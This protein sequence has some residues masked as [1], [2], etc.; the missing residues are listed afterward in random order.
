[1]DDRRSLLMSKEMQMKKLPI[2]LVLALVASALW[3]QDYGK[4]G[5]GLSGSFYK[6]TEDNTSGTNEDNDTTFFITGSF[7]A[8]LGDKMELRPSLTYGMVKET[9]DGS[10]TGGWSYFGVEFGLYWHILNTNFFRMGPGVAAGGFLGI[11]TYPSSDEASMTNIG[12]KIPMM[13][14]FIISRNIIF[15]VEYNMLL[16]KVNVRSNNS[17]D[18]DSY[19][20][21][22]FF[23]VD[24]TKINDE[25]DLFTGTQIINLGITFRF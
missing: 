5:V 3:A 20:D 14:E 11:D 4:F 1:M 24:P 21:I 6:W 9:E 17:G 18:S 13:M 22:A 8:M 2:I 16:F 12:L 7:S 19:Y 10:Q 23:P 15:R 25:N